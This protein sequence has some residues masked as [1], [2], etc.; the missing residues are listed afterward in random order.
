[1]RI[2]LY[3]H[4]PSGGALGHLCEVAEALKEAGHTL[5]LFCPA[6]AELEFGGLQNIVD[7][8]M[9]FQRHPWKA[10][11]PFLNPL[12]YRTYLGQQLTEEKYYVKHIMAFQPDGIYLGQCRLWTEPPLL[13]YLPK[14]LPKVIYCAEPK[15]SF[16][17]S[18]FIEQRKKWPFWKKLWRLPTIE[19]MKAEMHETILNANLVLC[20]S[21]YS[22]SYISSVYP[23]LSPEF[24]PIG[25]DCQKFKPLELTQQK[26]Q[27]LSV[28]A[29]DP[30]KN[31]DM[32]IKVA[33]ELPKD[34][35]FKVVI[36]TD[37][38]Y[39]D[40]ADQLKSLAQD[41][42]VQLEIRE[43]ISQNELIQVY[44]ES[45]ATIYCPHLEPFG[46]VS[47]ESQACGTPV[48]GKNEAGLKETILS[49]K[50]GE[51]FEDSPK[52]YALTISKWLEN[53]DLH[54]K[55]RKGARSNVL[56]NWNYEKTI[57]NHVLKLESFF[58]NF[59]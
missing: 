11:F 38:A 57:K 54:Q 30:S 1:M 36:V 29:L 58:E 9:V 27:L 32:A 50:S 47:I 59:N 24:T 17:E 15:R 10:F 55:Y 41:L 23:G 4:L 44:G 18:R 43:R 14:E 5:A 45:F 2:A 8:Q 6:T 33:A 46:R 12:L 42:Q 31:H 52:D 13:R 34:L 21:E 28:G 49:G 3:H 51:K 40:T 39:G 20:N 56:E 25:V 53:P 26:R 16:H 22:K 35:N 48:L 37:R 19:W 7:E